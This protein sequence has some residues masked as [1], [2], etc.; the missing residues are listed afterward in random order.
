MNLSSVLSFTNII[1][2]LIFFVSRIQCQQGGS[3]STLLITDP[4]ACRLQC[5]DKNRKFCAQPNS[6]DI[7]NCCENGYNCTRGAECSDDIKSEEFQKTNLYTFVC[8]NYGRCGGQ[9]LLSAVSSSASLKLD[10]SSSDYPRVGETC[11]YKLIASQNKVQNQLNLQFTK[12]AGATVTIYYGGSGLENLTTSEPI[13]YNSSIRSKEQQVYRFSGDQT[14][15]IMITTLS[16]TSL[17]YEFWYALDIIEVVEEPPVLN[18][19]TNTTNQTTGNNG[20]VIDNSTTPIG[21]GDSN[22]TDNTDNQNSTDKPPLPDSGAVLLAV[23]IIAGG[24]LVLKIV[25][26]IRK[27]REAQTARIDENEG[28]EKMNQFQRKTCML[29]KWS[30]NTHSNKIMCIF[31]CCAKK[32]IKIDEQQIN[33][34]VFQTNPNH[35]KGGPGEESNFNNFDNEAG[36]APKKKSGSKKKNKVPGLKMPS[37]YKDQGIISESDR[38][39]YEHSTRQHL[40]QRFNSVNDDFDLN[41]NTQKQNVKGQQDDIGSLNLHMQQSSCNYD[42]LEMST[43]NNILYG[44][45]IG[46][47][48]SRNNDYDVNDG[49]IKTLTQDNRESIGS[50]Y[51]NDQQLTLFQ[52]HSYS[53]KQFL[54]HKTSILEEPEENSRSIQQFDKQKEIEN[55]LLKSQFYGADPSQ[56]VRNSLQIGKQFSQEL[57]PIYLKKIDPKKNKRYGKRKGSTDSTSEYRVEGTAAVF[58]MQNANNF[59]NSRIQNSNKKLIRNLNSNMS[60]DDNQSRLSGSMNDQSRLS[61]GSRGGF[62]KKKYYRDEKGKLRDIRTK[63]EVEFKGNYDLSKYAANQQSVDFSK[64]RAHRP[65]IVIDDFRSSSGDSSNSQNIN[66]NKGQPTQKHLISQKQMKPN[67]K[68][69]KNN[70]HQQIDLMIYSHEQHEN[71]PDDFMRQ[72]ELDVDFNMNTEGQKAFN[73]KS[74]SKKHKKKKKKVAGKNLQQDEL[75]KQEDI[76]IFGVAIVEDQQQ[77]SLD[78]IQSDKNREVKLKN[79]LFKENNEKNQNDEILNNSTVSHKNQREQPIIDNQHNQLVEHSEIKKRLFENVFTPNRDTQDDKD[80]HQNIQVLDFDTAQ[81]FY[82]QNNHDQQLEQ[83]LSPDI[84][85]LKQQLIDELYNDK[86]PQYDNVISDF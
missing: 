18:N 4:R 74:V 82:P 28:H 30:L 27:K 6:Y 20:T 19:Q 31:I 75:K 71:I 69:S 2:S 15:Y 21:V 38:Q 44:D 73:G 39:N 48:G 11:S 58:D 64:K 8:P 83:I 63:E 78:I 40:M 52:Q 45:A 61:Q 76:N 51:T 86:T 72:N 55:N 46:Q 57:P 53:K 32:I 85:E 7:G 5:L 70:H 13:V 54:Q 3:Q 60:D 9:K 68:K 36:Q 22:G 41:K 42:H 62:D 43:Q 17:N 1:L 80:T 81:G 56:E 12:I 33:Q 84:N 50:Q 23:F 34:S 14:V 16:M 37:S 65:A 67:I 35:V 47:R 26:M 24:L 25:F 10:S 49:I 79:N 59:R 29:Q 77:I 66:P